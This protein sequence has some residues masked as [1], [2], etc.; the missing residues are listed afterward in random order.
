MAKSKK[1]TN[2]VM[3]TV[4]GKDRPGII[5]QTT[6]LLFK[7]GCNL[8]DVTMTILEGEFAMML[9]AS[10][11]PAKMAK[12]SE[13]FQKFSKKQNLSIQIKEIR[14]RLKQSHLERKKNVSALIQ[15]IGRDRAG[16]VYAISDVM[17]KK[18]LN[19]TDL[20]SRLIA[21]GPL[22]LYALSL[23]VDAPS[24]QALKWLSERMKALARKLRVEINVKPVEVLSF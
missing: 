16:I 9:V 8:E 17:A 18:N 13:V 15:V 19:I 20:N 11:D 24:E 21:E 1:K 4:T 6:C 12:L 14:H 22:E 23:E 3:V 7:N 10:C 2:H 5:A